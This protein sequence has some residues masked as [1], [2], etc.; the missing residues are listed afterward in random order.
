[1]PGAMQDTN[2]FVQPTKHWEE[3]ET[4]RRMHNLL[5]VTGLLDVVQMVKA[6][7]A[8]VD[9]LARYC[10]DASRFNYSD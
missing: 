10:E 9:Q 5:A 7:P 4:K 6:S 8:T 1:M 3:P 2:S